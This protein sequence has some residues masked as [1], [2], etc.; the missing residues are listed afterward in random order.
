VLIALAIQME[1][2]ERGRE[3]DRWIMQASKQVSKQSEED[4]R[5]P[6]SKQASKQAV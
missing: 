6:A 1:M 5:L 3:T 2:G 4:T